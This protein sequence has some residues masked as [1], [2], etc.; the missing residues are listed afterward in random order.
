VQENDEPK[1]DLVPESATQFFTIA[2]DVYTFETDAQGRVTQMILN[3]DG[4]DIPASESSSA[5]VQN[6]T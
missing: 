2:E 4:K 1:Q 5:K 3:V 6:C